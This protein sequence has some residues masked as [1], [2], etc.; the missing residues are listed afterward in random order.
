MADIGLVAIAAVSLGAAT[1]NGAL[2]Y[3]YSSLTV[4]VALLVVAG[5]VLNP[6]I[7]VVEVFVNLVALFLGR[8]A[9]RRVAP[10]VA[11][12]I[13]GLVPGVLLGSLL[14]ARVAPTWVKLI[15]F[16]VLLP[17]VLLQAAGLRWPLRRE[18][19][20]AVP[21]GTG[22]GLLYSLTTISGPPLAMFFNNQGYDR[23]DFK[24]AL[25]LTRTAESTLTLIAYASLGL[26]GGDSNAM[27]AWIAP[28]VLIGM[29]LGHALIRKVDA[30]AFRRLCV[31]F[32]VWLIGFGLSRVLASLHLVPSPWCYQ[33]LLVGVVADAWLLHGF[34]AARDRVAHLPGRLGG[35]RLAREGTP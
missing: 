18:R 2:G 6:A 23:A 34:F 30:G 35:D 16:G 8:G 25:A 7:V 24:V 12:L 13:V 22:V 17:L 21:L 29:P 1:V 33:V 3:G 31:T 10:R 28:G 15:T 11:P 14:L 32:D 4:P 27:I 5:R 19:V 20:A 26:L 9:V